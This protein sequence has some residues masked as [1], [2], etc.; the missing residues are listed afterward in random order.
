MS[1]ELTMG[2]A[3]QFEFSVLEDYREGRVSRS[4]AAILMGKSERTIDR[5]VRRVAERGLSGL[6]HGN[7]GRSPANKL[8]VDTIEKALLLTRSKYFDFNMT[9]CLEMLEKHEELKVSY[10]PFRRA[11]HQ[12]GLVKNKKK[13]RKKNKYHRDRM[14]CEG[15]LLQMDG[16]HHA[17]NGKDKWCLI[18]MIDDATS[19]IPYAEFFKSEDTLNC[20]KVIEAVIAAKGLP[21]AVYVD[22]AGWFGGLKRQEFSQ[23]LRAAEELGIR[24]IFANSPEAKGRIERA[25]KTFQDRLIPELRLYGHLTME[26]ANHYLLQVFLPTYWEK[27]NTVEAREINSKYREIPLNMDISQI[28]CLKEQRQVRNDLTIHFDNQLYKIVRTNVQLPLKGKK[29]EVR[30]YWNGDRLVFY[31]KIPLTLNLIVPPKP[32]FLRTA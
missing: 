16:S 12:V 23:F 28:C 15:L 3:E 4:E 21:R 5:K 2:K 32:R 24:V 31:G 26:Q 6:K 10:Q 25:W 9:H 7:R 20:L 19:D 8:A 29:V 17:W 13:I 27:R 30:T 14:A 11:C 18:A 22:K 1:G